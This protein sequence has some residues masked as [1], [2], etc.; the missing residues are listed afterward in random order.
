MKV[1]LLLK[2]IVLLQTNI[3]ILKEFVKVV[4][5]SLTAQEEPHL[6]IKDVYV[7]LHLS[8]LRLKILVFALQILSW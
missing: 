2:L 4:L 8:G 6:I 3:L 1:L 7:I 5:I